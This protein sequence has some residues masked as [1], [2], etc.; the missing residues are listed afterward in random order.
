MQFQA[1]AMLRKSST[2]SCQRRSISSTANRRPNPHLHWADMIVTAI[3]GDVRICVVRCSQLALDAQRRWNWSE[4][5]R[6][7]R[8]G[9]HAA[10]TNM[11][12]AFMVRGE[13]VKATLLR[14]GEELFAEA[15]SVGE[16]RGFSKQRSSSEPGALAEPPLL[17][18]DRI[19]YGMRQ[20]HHTSVPSCGDIRRTWQRVYDESEQISTFTYAFSVMTQRSVFTIW[21]VRP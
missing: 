16:V 2:R 13:R 10:F 11:Y 7:S 8:W 6:T 19:R 20:A 12:S 17:L 14:P 18:L 9:E 4:P 5:D 3:C 15:I 1:A 21:S